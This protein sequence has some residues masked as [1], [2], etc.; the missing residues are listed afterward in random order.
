MAKVKVEK[1]L[2]SKDCG[3][4]HNGVSRGDGVYGL[5]IIGAVVYYLPH[6]QNLQEGAIGIFKAIFWP[7]FLVYK[8]LEILNF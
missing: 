3:H 1:D 8:L 7:A 6:A 2:E 4:K 5:G